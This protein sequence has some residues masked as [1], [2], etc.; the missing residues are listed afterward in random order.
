MLIIQLFSFDQMTHVM[1]FCRTNLDCT[2]LE[3]FFQA[4]SQGKL[5]PEKYTCAVLGGM[6]S[7]EDRRRNLQRFKD[8]EVKILICTDVAARGIDIDSLAYVIN[9]TLPDAAEDYVH[10][11]GRAGRA[12]RMGLAISLVAVDSAEKVWYHTCNN[13]NRGIDCKNRHL[14]DKGGC[15]IWMEEGGLLAKVEEKLGQTIPVLDKESLD[16]PPSLAQFNA[17]YGES[18]AESML[19]GD[20]AK[21][22]MTDKMIGRLRTLAELEMQAQN[23]FLNMFVQAGKQG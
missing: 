18:V 16:L 19:L 23:I 20:G 5:L 9:M 21:V 15:T 4:Q 10:R 17:R 1:V 11:V 13:R 3:R 6:M 22:Y 8:G 2:N 14:K 12:E 7:M